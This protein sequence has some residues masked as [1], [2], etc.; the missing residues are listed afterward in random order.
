MNITGY[1]NG[2]QREKAVEEYKQNLSIKSKLNDIYEEAN[3][4]A[5]KNK[6]YGIVPLVERSKSAEE[7]IKDLS[8]Q[9][10]KAMSNLKKVL[11][12][13][14]AGE[15]LDMI[16]VNNDVV[17]FNRFFNQFEKDIG[18]QS[19]LTP[20]AFYQ[21]WERYKEKLIASGRTGIFI[22]SQKADIDALVGKIDTLITTSGLTDVEV[23]KVSDMV[24]FLYENNMNKQIEAI[25]KMLNTKKEYERLTRESKLERDD[26]VRE[27][28]KWKADVDGVI[29]GLIEAENEAKANREP[30]RFAILKD[31]EELVK[32]IDRNTIEIQ[33]IDDSLVELDR[34]LEEY[35]ITNDQY[36]A[37]YKKLENMKRRFIKESE[38]IRKVKFGDRKY[39]T[40]EEITKAWAQGNIDDDE[41]EQLL[42][43]LK[44]KP[45]SIG[46]KLS[47]EI[48][49]SSKKEPKPLTVEKRLAQAKAIKSIKKQEQ[50]EE[51]MFK[52]K[53][54]KEMKKK[55]K[56]QEL[57]EEALLEKFYEESGAKARA[58]EARL[59]RQREA[60]KKKL[61]QTMKGLKAQSYDDIEK[62]R[63]SRIAVNRFKNVI[64]E[65]NQ[66]IQIGGT[67]LLNYKEAIDILNNSP[68]SSRRSSQNLNDELDNI[69]N[70]IINEYKLDLNPSENDVKR[71]EQAISEQGSDLLGQI[72]EQELAALSVSAQV[73]ISENKDEKVIAEI[74]QDVND[75]SIKVINYYVNLMRELEQSEEIVRS[76]KS[77]EKLLPFKT[78]EGLV[79]ELGKMNIDELKQKADEVYSL[80]KSYVNQAY[81]YTSRKQTFN[82]KN[83][84][85]EKLINYI[86][87][88]LTGTSIPLYKAPALEQ[89][90]VPLGIIRPKK[91]VGT[92]GSQEKKRTGRGIEPIKNKYYEFGNYLIHVPHLEKG[93][94]SIKYP[95]EAPVKEFP[96]EIISSCFIRMLNDMIGTKKFNT[97][98]YEEL[99]DYEKELFDRLITFAKI[100]RN[101]IDNM[102]KHRKITDKQRDTDIKRFNIL[103]GEII[104][105]ND[106]PNVIKE[107]KSLLVKLHDQK[108]IGKSDFNKI[109]Q[110]IVYLT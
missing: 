46:T 7:E 61:F 103:K 18:G 6:T 5:S 60:K 84:I 37:E 27:K 62:A 24:G 34:K 81:G 54:A 50:H 16:R 76:K 74:E 65:I 23:K 101:D 82:A 48:V 45:K 28:K 110:T 109:M 68:R 17:E 64:D 56:E 25:Y 55:E 10:E 22:P 31:Y 97:D 49:Y 69:L 26:I 93:F 75:E 35:L 98:D 59:E 90:T 106:N 87:F 105:G 71:A 13:S 53:K 2:F 58:E 99:E 36:E 80:T 43:E 8:L 33:K 4:E 32:S 40:K 66:I 20:T 102:S 42:E 85:R 104:A 44:S 83:N 94:L 38:D 15:V 14:D 19:N 92:L 63:L 78:I 89:E 51:L 29:S 77:K 52:N 1:N 3:L 108:I 88:Q 11:K 9:N 30:N 70:E 67:N 96:K 12:I 57:S 95:S 91:P 73:A 79:D 86:V 21:L 41:Y 47:E 39:K 100:E 72:M 107:M